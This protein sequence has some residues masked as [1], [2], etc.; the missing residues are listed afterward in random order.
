MTSLSLDQRPLSTWMAP[1]ASVGL[2]LA[3]AVSE[4][5]SEKMAFFMSDIVF[6]SPKL[7]CQ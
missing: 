5:L 7:V 2:R 3:G 1:A 4:L 6:K